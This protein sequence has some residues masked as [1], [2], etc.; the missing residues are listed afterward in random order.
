M[1]DG[2]AT[3][4]GVGVG[5]R[6]RTGARL[7]E[8]D[9]GLDQAVISRGGGGAVAD[10][11][12]D[13]VGRAVDDEA[14]G[15][16]GDV[17]VIGGQRAGRLGEAVEVEHA[18]IGGR[19]RARRR[20]DVGGSEAEGAHG[21]M[22][23][24]GVGHRTREGHGV[25]AALGEATGAAE[26][27]EDLE[28]DAARA[29]V[30]EALVGR[31][32]TG[33]EAAVAFAEVQADERVAVELEA[34]A[35]TDGAEDDAGSAVEQLVGTEPAFDAAAVEVH[36]HARGRELVGVDL[37][38]RLAELDR[39]PV[40]G[41]VDAPAFRGTF[42]VSEGG[43]RPGPA[44]LV[45]VE[46]TEA[47]DGDRAGAEGAVMVHLDG[48]G[49]DGHRAV[50]VGGAIAPDEEHRIAPLE[51]AGGGDASVVELLDGKA[52]ADAG[53]L[54]EAFEAAAASKPVKVQGGVTAGEEGGAGDDHLA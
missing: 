7:D 48:A 41:A 3:D 18:G 42:V 14:A 33:I 12:G 51:E 5:E 20:E 53:T 6:E 13:G 36:G 22:G 28:H 2:G 10:R 17:R 39:L 19:E 24:T 47:V 11:Q 21:D 40:T 35:G 25:E 43:I 23:A 9:V 52:G 8:G 29:G 30:V 16:A 27:A 34:D 1:V 50:E 49:I 15:H 44:R 37:E 26:A 32:T 46:D 31:Q 54:I 38:G 4:V 45:D